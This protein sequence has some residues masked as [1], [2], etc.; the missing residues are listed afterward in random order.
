MFGKSPHT[1][2]LQVTSAVFR[3]LPTIISSISR[4]IDMSNAMNVMH[5]LS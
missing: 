5:A 4:I 1:E 2:I 3:N